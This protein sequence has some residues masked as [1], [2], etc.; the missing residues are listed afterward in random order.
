MH[1]RVSRALAG[2]LTAAAMLAATA[3][4]ADI[5]VNG[6]F[7]TGD[8]TGWTQFGDTTFSGVDTLAP[9]SGSYGAYF[10]PFS[11]GGI[12]QTLATDVSSHYIVEFWLQN[13][14][15]GFG[16]ATP[17]SFEL[18]WGG[19]PAFSITDAPAT[20]YTHYS[21]SLVATSALTDLAF[22]F[23]DSPAF[24]DLDNVTVTLVSEPGSLALAGLAG[25]LAALQGRRRR[26]IS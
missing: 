12:V 16:Q 3:A 20:G 2:C 10:G 9:Q 25:A 17:N 4:H 5:V 11:P 15:D 18:D 13:E 21:F 7:E 24:W 22:S 14:A 6:G 1:D 8:F 23:Q 19:S 26:V